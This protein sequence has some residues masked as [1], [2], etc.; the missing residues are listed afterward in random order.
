MMEGMPVTLTIMGAVTDAEPD[1]SSTVLVAAKDHWYADVGGGPALL[2]QVAAAELR[3][4]S[5]E[6]AGGAGAR[7]VR[8]EWV[9]TRD[10]DAVSRVGQAH[11]CPG[12][13]AGLDQA[14]SYL[15]AHPAGEVAAGTLW[16]AAAPESTGLSTRRG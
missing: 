16:W 11:D 14:L 6:I 15:A 13:R 8:A 9:I 5:E 3:E 10:Q 7:L 4:L 2:A 12:C 1:Y